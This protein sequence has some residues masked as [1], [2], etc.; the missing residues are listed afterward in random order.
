MTATS[1]EAVRGSRVMG[2][3][4]WWVMA[5]RTSASRTKDGRESLDVGMILGRVAVV[6]VVVV[7]GIAL[8]TE[9]DGE[10]DG[11][12]DSSRIR[13]GRTVPPPVKVAGDVEYSR[14]ISASQE[15]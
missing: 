15:S 2:H 6:V 8:V 12:G 14:E 4:V 10:G 7:A 3:V 11:G 13:V 1:E 9:G 5:S